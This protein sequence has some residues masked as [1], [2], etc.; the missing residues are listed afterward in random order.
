MCA[1][2]TSYFRSRRCQQQAA[3]RPTWPESKD[4]RPRRQG[5]PSPGSLPAATS[6]TGMLFRKR[7]RKHRTQAAP[8]TSEPADKNTYYSTQIQPA[9]WSPR[10]SKTA[11]SSACCKGTHRPGVATP[12]K[13][14]TASSHV[15][16]TC[17]ASAA[18]TAGHCCNALTTREY[19]RLFSSRAVPAGNDLHGD[20]QTVRRRS[21]A[22]VRGLD[23]VPRSSGHSFSS[24]CS[25]ITQLA[26]QSPYVV[27][28]VRLSAW[29]TQRAQS[30]DN[31]MN[32]CVPGDILERIA[33][34]C[35]HGSALRSGTPR[36]RARSLGAAPPSAAANC[37]KPSAVTRSSAL[38]CP[39]VSS[40]R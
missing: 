31:P 10:A 28:D 18:S 34:P 35:K 1:P 13:L 8:L 33:N 26:K 21:P 24:F 4:A 17:E 30:H 27:L 16:A 2:L 11:A 37:R 40:V 36:S 29:S 22:Q 20:I 9:R 6:L 14:A 3:L 23:D 19:P 12:C 7:R 39:A 38:A 15:T 5:L 25:G 32:Q